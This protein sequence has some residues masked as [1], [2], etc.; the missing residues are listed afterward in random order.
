MLFSANLTENEDLYNKKS[1]YFNDICYTYTSDDGTDISLLD[2][3]QE[4]TNK[5]LS[6]CEENCEFIK[7]TE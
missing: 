4:Y 1:G 5:N 7:Y 6:L 3:Q 2:R